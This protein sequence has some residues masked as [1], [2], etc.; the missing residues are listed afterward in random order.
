MLPDAWAID[1]SCFVLPNNELGRLQTTHTSSRRQ[2]RGDG[3]CTTVAD[4][5]VEVAEVV[6][7][8][9]S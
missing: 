8:V 4:T 9:R 3:S 1:H 6:V 5:T 2:I 7:V